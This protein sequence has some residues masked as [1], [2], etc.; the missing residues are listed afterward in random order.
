ML[1]Y[2]LFI[3]TGDKLCSILLLYVMKKLWYQ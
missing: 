1:S 2:M 3:T